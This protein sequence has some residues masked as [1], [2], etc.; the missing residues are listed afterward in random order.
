MIKEL[1]IFVMCPVYAYIYIYYAGRRL[2]WDKILIF[3]IWEKR[4]NFWNYKYKIQL[5]F[6]TIEMHCDI[7]N[8]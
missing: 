3:K 8:T 2:T 4:E 6:I 1:D 5:Y 7:I